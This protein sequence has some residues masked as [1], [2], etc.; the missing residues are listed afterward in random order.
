MNAAAPKRVW[1]GQGSPAGTVDSQAARQRRRIWLALL[2]GFGGGYLIKDSAKADLINGIRAVPEGRSFLSPKVSRLLEDDHLRQLES[3]GL[4]D[5]YDLLTDR[6]REILQLVAEGRT[7]KEIANLL[8]ISPYTIDRHSHIFFR[9]S[10]C[11][12]LRS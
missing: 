7:N 1:T 9:S 12:A 4:E 6:E 2:A 10:I 3:K 5:S 11:T 8:N